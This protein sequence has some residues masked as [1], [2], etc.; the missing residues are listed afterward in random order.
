MQITSR[1]SGMV[2][3]ACS[4]LVL[5]WEVWNHGSVHG[6]FNRQLNETQKATNTSTVDWLSVDY[7]SQ[8]SAWGIEHYLAMELLNNLTKAAL[9]NLRRNCMKKFHWEKREKWRFIELTSLHYSGMQCF[10]NFTKID[11][12][13]NRSLLRETHSDNYQKLSFLSRKFER[14]WFY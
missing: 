6:N 13:Q 8:I 14:I 3:N 7:V 9:Q 4:P 12:T 1:C 11:L 10:P 2:G 5:A